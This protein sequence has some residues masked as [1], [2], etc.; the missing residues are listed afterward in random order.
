MQSQLILAGKGLIEPPFAVGQ[1]IFE[2]SA[3][4]TYPGNGAYYTVHDRTFVVPDN[5]KTKSYRYF[6]RWTSTASYV[7]FA[8]RT[9]VYK[10]GILIASWVEF[11]NNFGYFYANSGNLDHSVD[12][13][14]EAGDTLRGLM[15]ASGRNVG[16]STPSSTL[17]HNLKRLT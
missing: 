3:T 11:Q 7:V 1:A 16:G 15:R 6:M 12:F 4:N 9:D 10:N 8:P 2:D 14:L 17:Y 5:W 13:S